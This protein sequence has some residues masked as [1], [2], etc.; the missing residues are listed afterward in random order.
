MATKHAVELH[1]NGYAVIRGF[2]NKQEV[3]DL[4]RESERVY[5]EGLK[6]RATYP[7]VDKPS[8]LRIPFLHSI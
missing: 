2:L 7:L 3:A 5:A 6:H 4:R 8:G 1:E